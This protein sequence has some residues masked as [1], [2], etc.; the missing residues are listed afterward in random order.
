MCN[1]CLNL[2]L[3]MQKLKKFFKKNNPFTTNALPIPDP[4]TPATIVTAYAVHVFY[5][6]TCTPYSDCPILLVTG[7]PSLFIMFTHPSLS[8]S[9]NHQS[10]SNSSIHPSILPETIWPHQPAYICV[11]TVIPEPWY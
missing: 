6:S 5:D 10:P 4:L 1:Q 7:Q 3:K 2:K 9:H 8:T 11:S